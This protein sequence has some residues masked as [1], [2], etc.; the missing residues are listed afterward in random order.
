MC[1]VTSIRDFIRSNIIALRMFI[2]WWRIHIVSTSS[3]NKLPRQDIVPPQFHYSSTLHVV[4]YAAWYKRGSYQSNF[5]RAG[6][7]SSRFRSLTLRPRKLSRGRHWEVPVTLQ[8]T[9]PVPLGI[10]FNVHSDGN[11][12][13]AAAEYE[14]GIYVSLVNMTN[15]IPKGHTFSGFLS[16]GFFLLPRWTKNVCSYQRRWI[17]L[18]RLRKFHNAKVNAIL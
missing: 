10:S 1:K 4:A 12:E 18:F 11:S 15:E 6:S 5:T 9:F 2:C 8:E 7:Q 3:Q 14:W 16:R 17:L 13:Q